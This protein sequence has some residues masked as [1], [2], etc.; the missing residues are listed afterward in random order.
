MRSLL[1]LLLAAIVAAGC[2]TTNP[3]QPAPK[4]EPEAV[5]PLPLIPPH[6]CGPGG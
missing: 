3:I 4:A 5:A 2:H 6:P 1:A